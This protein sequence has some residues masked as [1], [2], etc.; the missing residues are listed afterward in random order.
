[1]PL[2]VGS[3]S[4]FV[5]GADMDQDGFSDILVADVARS[6]F[7][8]RSRG[9]G[10]F[11]PPVAIAQARGARWI[12]VADYDGDRN[13]DFASSNFGASNMTVFLG[14]GAGGFALKYTAPGAREHTLE[15][16]DFDGDGNMDLMQGSGLPGVTP[17]QGAGDGTFV[18]QTNV[19]NLSCIEYIAEVGYYDQNGDYVLI[20]D[21][22]LDGLGDLAVTCIDDGTAYAGISMG[23]GTYLRTFQAVGGGGT[24]SLAIGDLNGDDLPDLAL[25]SAGSTNL[26]VYPGEGD[27]RF[28]NPEVFGPTGVNPV[29]LISQDLDQDG[30]L[31]VVSADNTSFT[32]T[33]FWGQ[34]G[35][36]FIQSGFG[37]SGYIGAK[38]A[39]AAD[40]DRD[41][42]P[43]L[44]LPR[45]DQ[46]LINVYRKPGFSSLTAPSF[47][48]VT[49][50]KYSFLQAADLDR[51]GIV[52]LAGA[53]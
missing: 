9:D 13:L 17:F 33:V 15:T 51:D 19:R 4:V 35:D 12:A 49:E 42:F 11:A 8:I 31:D 21:F 37:L 52:D 6:A 30:H 36:P 14:N 45:S 53:D 44:L 50:S 3:S 25:V 39:A 38:A 46:T 16:L 34:E 41:G 7:F 10:T 40:V 5:R 22:N 43:D 26:W 27:G 23:D 20:G 1:M 48:I 18:P 2:Q 32:L 28:Q 24:E 47:T 29:F